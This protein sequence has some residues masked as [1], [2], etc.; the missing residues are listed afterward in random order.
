MKTTLTAYYQK[1]TKILLFCL[2]IT[3]VFA[4]EEVGSA[5]W[6]TEIPKYE[7]KYSFNLMN[8]DGTLVK[9]N[10]IEWKESNCKTTN[11]TS[12]ENLYG[13][14]S[15]WTSSESNY[16]RRK[17]SEHPVDTKETIFLE[18]K[19]KGKLPIVSEENFMHELIHVNVTHYMSREMC[20]KN[21][22]YG[23]CS[24]SLSYNYVHLYQQIKQLNKQKIIKL[25]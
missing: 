1:I 18:T 10:L 3:P 7:I 8:R 17:D 19:W 11:L 25:I 21:W 13:C 5:T 24:E 16:S 22:R 12:G 23:E 20:E 2:L 14:I 6:G 9:V 4:S 15:G